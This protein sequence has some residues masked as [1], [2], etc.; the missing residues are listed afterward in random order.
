MKVLVFVVAAAALTQQG[1]AQEGNGPCPNDCSGHGLC[2]VNICMCFSGWV[3]GDCSLRVCPKDFAW[4]DQATGADVAHNLAECSNRGACDRE[5]GQCVCDLGFH[6]RACQF[7]RCPNNCNGRGRCVDM[8][9]NALYKDPGLGTIYTYD[10]VWDAEK[11]YGCIC[12]EGFTGYDCSLRHCPKG[13]DPLTTSQ[14]NEIQLF[15]CQATQG[16]FT[17]T[18]RGHTSEPISYNTLL[19]DFVALLEAVPGVG[20]LT[21]TFSEAG[22]PVCSI[23]VDQVVSITFNERFGD[24]E[25]L[26]SY[27]TSIGSCSDP[28]VALY[29]LCGGAGLTFVTDG[30]ALSPTSGG[31]LYSVSGTKENDYCSGRGHCDLFTGVCTCYTNFVTS[32][33]QGNE[34]DRGDCGYDYAPVQACPGIIACSGHGTCSNAPSYKC[35]CSLGWTS[36]DCSLR[37]CPT[38][39]SWF[40]LPIANNRAHQAVECSNQGICD[41]TTGECKCHSGFEGAACDKM[42]CPGSPTACSGNG[43]CLTMSQL[44]EQATLNGD[45]ASTT[46][47]LVP[48]DPLRWD[49]DMVMG[50][51]CDDGF[52]GHDCS[53]VS[54]P[55]GDDP[56]TF[57]QFHETQVL[58]CNGDGGNIRLY[59][60]QHST[61]PIPYNADKD[62]LQAALVAIDSITDVQIAFSVG[63]SLCTTDGSNIVS[64]TFAQELG[65]VPALVGFYQ[66]NGVALTHSTLTANLQIATDGGSLGAI[67]A[68]Q[69]TMEN[70]ECSGRG[71]CNYETGTCQCFSGFASSNGNNRAGDRGDCGWKVPW[72]TV[73]EEA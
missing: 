19:A 58:Q 39:K 46:Y 2:N 51:L 64:I 24:I 54:C 56:E 63:S 11:L 12:D 50:C 59:F 32:D 41:Q 37:T 42:S 28:D 72:G 9:Y 3:G 16:S 55:K 18:F 22:I 52:E 6:G 1:Q 43:Q 65:D 68:Q 27:S 71:I 70:I 35:T 26:F 45:S 8:R 66:S 29:D 7:S 23:A 17:L 15:Q 36:G 14:E 60:R 10:Q 57:M 30:G 25:S 47:G 62:T 49:Y 34:G 31:T 44:A 67:T 13:D 73:T 40:D 38:G 48:N 5:T 21:A 61:D 69:G 20:D 53:L 33:G 4:N